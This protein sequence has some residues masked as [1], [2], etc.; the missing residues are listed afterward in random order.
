MGQ[1]ARNAGIMMTGIFVSRVLGFVRERAIAE[2]FGRTGETDAFF[3]A[4]AIP[5]LMY[6]IL[7][8]GALGAAF[9]PVFTS[10]LAQ[11]REGEGWYV[12]ST[13]INV[14]VIL[15]ISFTLLGMIFA[16]GLAPL[17]AYQFSGEQL[18][19]LVFLMRVM[20]PAVLFTALAGLTI[21]ILQS[22][23]YFLTPALGP[24]VYNVAII[25]SAYL[26]GPR[27]GIT[28]MA[29]GVVIGAVG[30]FVLQLPAAW[31]RNG[32]YRP[33]IDIHHEGIRRM[34]SLMLP[35]L[36]GLSIGQINL[37]ISQNLASG[38]TGGITA[39]RLANRLMQFPLGVFAMGISTALFPSLTRLAATERWDEFK[40]NFSLAIRTV[41]MI[42]IPSGV[43]L[44]ALRVPIVRLLFQSGQ[45]TAQ[46]TQAT[47]F[48]LL[49]YSFGLF[50]QGGIQLT[51]KAFYSLQDARTPVKIGLLN[52]LFN[53][54]LSIFFLQFT[55]L[56]HGGL[57]LAFSLTSIINLAASL[58]LL[59]NK[60]GGIGGPLILKT[61]AKSALAA[62]VMGFGAYYAG[63]YI[64]LVV[65]L[66]RT[67]G[68]LIQVGGGIAVGVLLYAVLIFLLRMEELE[69]V[70]NRVKGRLQRG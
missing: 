21:G 66:Q 1:V 37:I 69:Y 30:N 63:E 4:F 19:L 53:T 27:L 40:S 64:G 11:D 41:F 23:Q 56:G 20:F 15:L 29:V 60:L 14:T 43:G 48:A 70:G 38:L 18:E 62:A 39:L 6:Y 55:G 46:D 34:L 24:I 51:T 26:L 8:G 10:Y 13:F 31:G 2:V 28:G 42:T 50:A 16:P 47:A 3:A 45:F 22:Y 35:A 61:M 68:R 7:V 52:I 25:G 17:V 9:I 54:L 58:Y 5:D 49:F 67:A 44:L 36:V 32:G 57:A 33:I 65:D 12:A 59:R